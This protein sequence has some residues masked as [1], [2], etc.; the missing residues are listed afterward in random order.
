MF[1]KELLLIIKRIKKTIILILKKIL[2]KIGN[3]WERTLTYHI[4]YKSDN[5][6]HLENINKNWECLGKNFYLSLKV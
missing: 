1:W 5:T 3:V 2:I 4:R 6:L